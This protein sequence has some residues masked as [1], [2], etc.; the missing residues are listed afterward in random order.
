MKD[1]IKNQQKKVSEYIFVKRGGEEFF[2]TYFK[3]RNPQS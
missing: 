3:S 2:L 1:K